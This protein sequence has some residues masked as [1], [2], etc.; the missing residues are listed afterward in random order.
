LSRHWGAPYDTFDS[1]CQS[2]I[3][4]VLEMTNAPGGIRH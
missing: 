3:S 1:K 4:R 2:S